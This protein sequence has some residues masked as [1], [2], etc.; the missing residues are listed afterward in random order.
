MLIL[1]EE[2]RSNLQV[3]ISVG[4]QQLQEHN[5]MEGKIVVVAGRKHTAERKEV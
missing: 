3:L 2:I 4:K 5:V 1:V